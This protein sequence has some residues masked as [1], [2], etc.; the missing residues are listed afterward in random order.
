MRPHKA[1]YL[2]P[3][4][5]DPCCRC[6][7]QGVG[8]GVSRG[9]GRSPAFRQPYSGLAG[10]RRY[11]GENLPAEE[12]IECWFGEPIASGDRAAVEWWGSWREQGQ[13]LTFAGV[14]VLRFDDHG[15]VVDHR[16]Y[17]NHVERREAPYA[18]LVSISQHAYAPPAAKRTDTL[19]RSRN[20][21]CRIRR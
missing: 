3:P 10:V 20:G 19:R 14:T 15:K 16:D 6:V 12:N 1:P 5:P 4:R 7:G 2:G 11:L 18:G 17:D 21:G 8:A 13:E 9:P